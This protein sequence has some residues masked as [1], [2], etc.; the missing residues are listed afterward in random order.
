[1]LLGP[2]SYLTQ[3]TTKPQAVIAAGGNHFDAAAATLLDGQDGISQQDPVTRQSDLTDWDSL[4][5]S[6][7]F[8]ALTGTKILTT[9]PVCKPHRQWFFQTHTSAEWQYPTYTL[10]DKE[11]RETYLIDRPLWS[12]LAGEIVFK[13]MVSAINRQGV[14]F[15]WP[16]RMPDPTG[17]EDKWAR[18]ALEFAKLAMGKWVRVT[19]N[20]SLGAYEVIMAPPGLPA[21]EWP[22]L[23]FPTLL[24]IAFR[25]KIIRDFNHPVLKRLRGEL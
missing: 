23:E 25:E 21:P 20:M 4:R 24:D 9:I 14:F 1:M 8:A 11:N 22:E 5:V 13:T 6:Q 12:A 2:R 19:S 16:V 18:S 17:R 7:D 3:N 10:E 15:F